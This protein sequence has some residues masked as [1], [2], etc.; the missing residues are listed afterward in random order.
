MRRVLAIKIAM[1]IYRAK[2]F[3]SCA[4]GTTIFLKMKKG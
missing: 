2:D 1:L 3:A 4:S